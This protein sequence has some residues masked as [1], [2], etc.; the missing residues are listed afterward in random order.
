MYTFS[1]STETRGWRERERMNEY[2]VI[3]G[4][5]VKRLRVCKSE[6]ENHR[7]RRGDGV[8]HSVTVTKG[9]VTPL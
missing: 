9:N 2:E 7:L 4:V 8:G 3:L 5:T 6:A 1:G